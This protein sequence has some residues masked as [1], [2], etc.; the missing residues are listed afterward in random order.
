[1]LVAEALAGDH[2]SWNAIV[3]R[4]TPLVLS[5]VR[6][7]RLSSADAEDVVQ[8]VWLRLVEHLRDVRDPRA[9]PRYIVQ[10]ATHEC[11][12]LFGARRH[13]VLV[14]PMGPGLPERDDA[15]EVDSRMLATERQEKLLAALADLPDRQRALLLLF[16]EDPPPSYE[17]ISR[18]LDMPIGSIGPTRAR[19]LARLREVADVLALR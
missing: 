8:V 12:R 19:A 3:E 16:L 13:V 1:M 4:Y 14:D 6:R 10:T 17:E 9:L 15:P 7:Q 2:R 18:R 11:Y 5:V